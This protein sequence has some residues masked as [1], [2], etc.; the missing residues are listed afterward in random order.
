MVLSESKK[1]IAY[2]KHS[3]SLALNYH[4]S[5]RRVYSD[6]EAST[7]HVAH[8]LLRC[9]RLRI[10]EGDYIAHLCI[11]ASGSMGAYIDRW[12]ALILG[13]GSRRNHI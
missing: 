3:A 8:W 9:A 4:T 1:A 10:K 7:Q 11:L 13:G 12:G 6:L 2:P 5:S